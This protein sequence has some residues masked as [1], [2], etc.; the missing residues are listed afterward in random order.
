[1]SKFNFSF[2]FLVIML[3]VSACGGAAPAATEA[4][5]S[6]DEP[7]VS[8]PP[9]TEAA[10]VEAAEVS[11]QLVIYSG[12]SEPLLGGRGDIIRRGDT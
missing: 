3:L 5:V 6:T 7:S 1:M 12:R 9:A 11:G 2:V 8:V 4:P 10:T